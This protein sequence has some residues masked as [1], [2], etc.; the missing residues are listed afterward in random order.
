[1]PLG[2]HEAPNS[3]A[4]EGQDGSLWLRWPAPLMLCIAPV[5]SPLEKSPVGRCEVCDGFLYIET[6]HSG[7]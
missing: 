2:H 7:A 5:P 3:Q 1:M 4:P 6:H